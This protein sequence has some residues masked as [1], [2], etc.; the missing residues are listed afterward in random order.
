MEDS[1]FRVC[2]FDSNDFDFAHG[3]V[4]PEGEGDENLVGSHPLILPTL[5]QLIEGHPMGG[6]VIVYFAGEFLACNGVAQMPEMHQVSDQVVLLVFRHA[7]QF[8]LNLIERHTPDTI[9]AGHPKSKRGQQ[10]NRPTR[11]GDLFKR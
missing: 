8:F 11:P 7:G 4:G 2:L 10:D 5:A 9:G 3:V 1:L 6:V